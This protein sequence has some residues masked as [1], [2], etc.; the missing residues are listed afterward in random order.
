M[1][2]WYNSIS[3]FHMLETKKLQT[4]R[5]SGFYFEWLKPK[6]R[7]KEFGI[8]KPDFYFTYS[9]SI[10]PQLNSHPIMKV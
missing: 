10:N 7:Q 3:L 2:G 5:K 9:N 1:A 4:K 8:S 6:L